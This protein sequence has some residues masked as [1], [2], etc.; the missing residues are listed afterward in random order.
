MIKKNKVFNALAMVLVAIL[1]VLNSGC[2]NEDTPPLETS[3]NL[4][5]QD[6]LG[7]TGT[8]TFIETSATVST[9]TLKLY[10][11]PSGTH[12]A[13]L[14]MNSVVEG[15]E[16]VQEL[17]PVDASGTSSTDVNL[18]TYNQLIAYD[19]FIKVI[20]SSN[21]PNI[22]LVQGDIGGN[23]LTG[24]KTTFV[25]DT[26]GA[27]GVSGTAL[28]EKRE[29]G[30]T[31]VTLSLTGAIA[32]EMYPATI[33]LSS[34]A[35]IG[36]GPVTKTLNNVNGTTGKSFTNI[37]KLDEGLKITYDN[38]LVY[39]GYINIYQTAVDFNNIISHGNIG[40]NVNSN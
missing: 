14:Y 39:N 40:S 12:P 18:L 26:I 9:I 17:N 16:I 7:V 3:F 21:E 20:K 25:L 32:E 38:W 1:P 11:A 29:N 10:G 28:F 23:V 15:G 33:N 2:K 19:G 22:I 6:V 4:K 24:D 36:G 5:V 37:R 30:N 34:V 27:F 13:A 31:L 35:T 8:A